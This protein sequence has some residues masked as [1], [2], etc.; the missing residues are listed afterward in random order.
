[1][2]MRAESA[3][4]KPVEP[5]SEPPLSLKAAAALIPRCYDNPVWRGLA[6]FARDWAIYLVA[7]AVLMWSDTPWVLVPAWL[8]AGA[9]ISGLF[10]IGH[11]A[12]HGALFRSARLNYWVAQLSMLP[13]LHAFDVWAYGHNRIHHAFAACEGMDFVWHPTTVAQYERLSLLGKLLHRTEWSALGSGVYYARA[14]WWGRIIRAVP[15]ARLEAAFRR[16]RYLIGAYA[17]GTSAAVAVAGYQLTGHALGALWCWVK[18]LMVP[19]IIWNYAIGAT[20]YIH[21]IAPQ[22][23][24][25][26]RRRWRKFAAQIE[27]TA[28]VR[29]PGWLNFFWHNIYVHTPHHVDPSIPFYHLPA[30]AASLARSYPDLV[31]V[32]AYH[33][34]DFVRTTRQC[35]LYDFERSVWLGYDGAEAAA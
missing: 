24:W 20:V 29:I 12:A 16:D 11:D 26:P 1:M 34:D 15:P 28:T 32:R 14:M 8:I 27:S 35:K 2:R 4:L 31:Q 17:I 18:V 22:I 30:A 5:S 33:L 25:H 13:S 23:A 9:T 7:V 21:H 3:L 10:V 19:W 6:V